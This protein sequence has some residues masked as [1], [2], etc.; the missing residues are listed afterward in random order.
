MNGPLVVDSLR[1]GTLAGRDDF[2]PVLGHLDEAVLV[3]S[4]FVLGL[5]PVPGEVI[6]EHRQTVR[7][8]ED[9]G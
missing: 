1:A 2:I 4:L 3:P 8:R 6:R 5:A 9:G 7:N